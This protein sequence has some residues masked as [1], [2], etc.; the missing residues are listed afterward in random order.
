M[1]TY[2]FVHGAWHAGEQMLDTA[3]VIRDAG[4]I[5]HTPTLCGNGSADKKNV[6]LEDAIDSLCEFIHQESLE[7]FVLVGHSYAG[8]VITGVADKMPKRIRRLVYWNAFVP[9]NG[10]SLNDLVPPHYVELFDSLVGKD[11]SVVLPYPIWREAFINNADAELAASAYAVLN[12]HPYRTFSDKIVLKKNPSDMTIPKSYINATEDTAL[13]HSHGWHPRL[14][15]K[16]GLFRLVQTA[17]DHEM[18]F[19]NPDG[20]AQAIM[21]AGGD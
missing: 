8:M 5:V 19:T 16:L 11:G 14:S 15:E 3:A 17:G 2:L 6:G 13:P 20:L 21:R 12:P 9:N 18:C 1:A 7:D 4:N 10:E